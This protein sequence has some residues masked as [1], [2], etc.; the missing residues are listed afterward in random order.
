MRGEAIDLRAGNIFGNPMLLSH[1][2]CVEH[3]NVVFEIR[4]VRKA[5]MQGTAPKLRGQVNRAWHSNSL[6]SCRCLDET[7]FSESLRASSHII[8]SPLSRISRLCY[9]MVTS[10]LCDELTV[11]P[12]RFCHLLPRRHAPP[13][14]LAAPCHRR[15]GD[16]RPLPHILGAGIGPGTWCSSTCSIHWKYTP[17]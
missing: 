11:K 8:P 1:I 13:P 16:S 9:C 3:S 15:L 5:F 7:L 6:R 10:D 2:L 4:V 12:G 17:A 14:G